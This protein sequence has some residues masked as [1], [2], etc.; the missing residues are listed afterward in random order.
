VVFIK[1]MV[2]QSI[3]KATFMSTNP[4]LV[5]SLPVN[6]PPILALSELPGMF[7]MQS[8][9]FSTEIQQESV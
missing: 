1:H 7:T 6:R 4:F 5:A 9:M 3:F 2:F 8:S